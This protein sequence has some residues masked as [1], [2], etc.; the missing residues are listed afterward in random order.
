VPLVRR[1]FWHSFSKPTVVKAISIVPLKRRSWA[2][3]IPNDL[4]KILESK[5]TLIIV[6]LRMTNKGFYRKLIQARPLCTVHRI[7]VDIE[8]IYRCQ[9][10]CILEVFLKFSKGDKEI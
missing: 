2:Y 6:V 1:F 3:F 5:S 7:A 8:V 4:S 9:Q 10:N